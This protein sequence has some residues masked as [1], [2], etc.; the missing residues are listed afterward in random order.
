[1][2]RQYELVEKVKAYD[3]QVDE[4]L[5]NR[6]YVFSVSAH[7]TQLRASGDPYYSHPIEV[8]GIL[9]ELKLDVETIVTA[10][11]HDTIEDTVATF[12]QIQQQFGPSIATLVDGVTKLSRLEVQTETERAAENFRKFVLAMSKDI[13]VLLVKLA[14]RLHNMRTL[15]HLP[16]PQKRARIARETM[17]IYAPLAD[18]I[19]MYRFKNELSEIAFR[20]LEPEG[21]ESVTLQLAKLRAEAGDLVPTIER[22]LAELLKGAGIAGTIIGREKLPHSIW[23][24]MQNKTTAFQDVSDITAFR[25]IVENEAQVY[26]A[27]GLIH[28]HWHMVPN[29]FKDYISTPKPNGYRSVHTTVEGPGRARVEIQL[30]TQRM[31]D[32]AEHGLAAHWAYKLGL[33]ET[34]PKT[35][36]WLK[37]LLDIVEQE[38]GAE[39]LLE[40]SRLAMYEDQI[41]CFTPKG[42]LIALPK[43]ATCLD[44]AYAVHTDIGDTTVGAKVKGVLMP[45]RTVLENGDRVEILRSSTSRPD[46]AW[47][48]FVVTGKARSAIRR[49]TRQLEKEEERAYGARVLQ[50]IADRLKLKLED[51]KLEELCRGLHLPD[52][53]HLYQG[54][55][56]GTITNEAVTAL[57]RPGPV[58]KMSRARAWFGWGSKNSPQETPLSM[59][60]AGLTP[61][62]TVHM[63][64]CCHPVYG[65]RVVGIREAGQGV[66]VHTI[67]CTT[68]EKLA[69]VP[70]RW[71]DL[72]W[73]DD[74]DG[75]GPGIARLNVVMQNMQGTLAT[76]SALLANADA[77]IV[78]LRM[79]DRDGQLATILLDLEVEDLKHL[80]RVIVALRATPVISS[81]E[82]VRA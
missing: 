59:S 38:D 27:L 41:F 40:N 75:H 82:R 66:Q 43:G 23:Q 78:N 81:V 6:A 54:L 5:L 30:R 62:V 57:L 19:G 69:H 60:L 67:D 9:T 35:Y 33:K 32:E 48:S 51:K 31:H 47:A 11:L 39:D 24:K 73:H 61:G 77:N 26:A 17:D 72:R 49:Y 79:T 29:R 36:I 18:R 58:S 42:K 13:R 16:N 44:F 22:E 4:D 15:H 1:M 55:A 56:R 34:E 20:E 12:D 65:D 37:N 14:D 71:I 28:L 52:H 63:A 45:L 68:L 50:A 25:V 10:I 21:Y 76:V 80:M 46:P 2:L 3:P 70:D 53:D 7:G 74:S 64:K 8:A